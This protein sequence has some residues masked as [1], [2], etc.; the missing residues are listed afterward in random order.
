MNNS[1]EEYMDS[2][3]EIPNGENV[4]LEIFLSVRFYF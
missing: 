3:L 4:V 2:T 1:V